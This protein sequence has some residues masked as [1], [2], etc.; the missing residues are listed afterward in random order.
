MTDQTPRPDPAAS[1]VPASE[2]ERDAREAGIHSDEAVESDDAD[3]H[4]PASEA[5]YLRRDV[6]EVDRQAPKP[7]LTPPPPD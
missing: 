3:T 2:L 6:D 7:G 1:P 4:L 5:E